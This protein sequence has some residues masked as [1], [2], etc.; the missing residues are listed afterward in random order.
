MSLFLTII[1][2]SFTFNYVSEARYEK[3]LPSAVLVGTV[4]CNTCFQEEFSRTSHFISG[5]SVAVECG[6]TNSKPSFHEEVKTNEYGEFRVHLP[7]SVSKHVKK[8]KGCSVKL[9]SSSE[10]Y[11][12][13]ASTA[14]SSS[15][16][17]KSRNHGTHTFSAGFFTFKPL[18]QPNL[19][20]QKPSFQNPK[21]LKFNFTKSLFPNP[22]YTTFPPPI[23][24]PPTPFLPPLDK[25]HFHPL[26]QLPILPPLPQLPPLPPLPG[27]PYFPPLP[28][29]KT[30]QLS[31]QKVAQPEFFHR[32]PFV[33]SP[34]TAFG[35]PLPP[36]PF[37]PPSVLPPNPFRPPS[38]LPPNPFRPPSVLPP[39]PFRP[40]PSVLPPNPFRPPPSVLPPNPFQPSPPL[41]N[42]PPVPGS[43]P[44]QPTPA[45]IPFPFPPLRFQPSPDIP[46]ASSSKK[47]SP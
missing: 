18:K 31:K 29:K 24:D 33:P 42:L 37:R 14:S 44:S 20:N 17:L 46:P 1:I 22:D 26:P 28:G 7:F 27:L 5:A 15:L 40:P 9:I 45:V 23:Q 21:K 13:V 32:I 38:V 12:A 36:N 47:T 39:N 8:I 16:H 2:L 10:P 35:I 43:T 41:T 30:S 11:C 25:N 4:Y 3:K 6:D 19:C 34:P